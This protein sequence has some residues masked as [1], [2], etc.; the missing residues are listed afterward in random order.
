MRRWGFASWLAVL[1]V[2]MT[3][4][5]Q[6]AEVSAGVGADQG[7][8]PSQA[9]AYGAMPGGQHAPTAE[10]LPKGAVEVSTLMGFG[11]RSGLLGPDHKFNRGIGDLAIAFGATDFL[12]IGLSLDGR[13]DK[14]SG[15]VGDATMNTMSTTPAD[16]DGYVGDPHLIVRLA[17]GTGSTLLGGQLGIWVPGKDA[18][19]V[20]GS[21]ISIDARVLVSLPAG[22][23]L[24]SFSGGFRLDNSAK[25]VDDPMRLSL[26]DRVSLGVSD[27]NALFAGAQLRI[28]AGK[29]AWVAFE[30]S[31][32]AFIGGPPD[33]AAG[34]V[35]RAELARGKLIFRGGITGG[36]HITDQFSA[37]AF[38]EAAKVPG[39]NDAQIDDANIPLVP[40]EPIF[41]GGIGVQARF[42]GPKSVAPTF[43]ERDCAKHNP[44]DCPDVKVP[45][46][47]EISGT[48][49]D[50][51]G[52]PV[53]GAKVSLGLKLSQVN[54]VVTDEKGAYVFKGVPIGHKLGSQPTIDET[55][56]E[57]TV[58]VG[59]MK[60]GKATVSQLAEG[61]T[62]A[63]PITLEPVLPP[64]QLRGV[65]RSLPGGKAVAGATVTVTGS[66]Q[67]ATTEADGTF[68]IDL[69]PGQYKIKV[70]KA[71]LKDQELD[72]T[73][74]PNGVAIKNI[75]L[76]K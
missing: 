17:K 51:A 72:V 31:L 19:S 36:F 1:L 44:P 13:Y 3:V 57:I 64:G 25:S 23:G 43:T 27:Y 41:T 55:A 15:A 76:Q 20:A 42:G 14:H 33:P 39:I 63:P 32:D 65:V 67:K 8:A 24:L 28:P 53:V 35:K 56:G 9:I 68:T 70:S 37:I 5:A 18:P 10:T 46:V 26:S 73:I 4:S 49:V 21:A 75:D 52:K 22:P 60:P 30:G 69:A 40:Y 54:P 59:N 50:N 58:E 29:K 47:T 66:Q 2:P 74:D 62:T 16:D 11:H 61:A 7:V 34:E 12:S 6:E 38:L 71:G 48:V 45:I